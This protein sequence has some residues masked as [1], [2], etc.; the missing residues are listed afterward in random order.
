MNPSPLQPCCATCK[1]SHP[2]SDVQ[3]ACRRYP[4]TAHV[5]MAKQQNVLTAQ[6]TIAPQSISTMVVVQPD[7]WCGEFEEKQRLALAS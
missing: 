7:G 6:Q 5:L 4:P 1:F 3:A 2:L